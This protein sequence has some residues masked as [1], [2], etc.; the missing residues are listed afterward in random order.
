[1][2]INRTICDPGHTPAAVAAGRLRHAFTLVELMVVIVI[3]GILASLTLAGLAG[4]RQRAK[5]EKTKSTIRK[6][7]AVIQPMYESYLTRRV[8]PA[9]AGNRL[10]EARAMVR[11]KRLLMIGEMPD[12]WADVYLT[13][14][15]ALS[16]GGTRLET[17]YAAYRASAD[18]RYQGAECLAMIVLRGGF[19]PDAAE[20][21][22]ADELGDIDKDGAIEFWD[23]W[24]RPIGFI[25]WAAGFSSL[26]QP[27]NT[28]LVPDPFDPLRQTESIAYPDSAIA[29]TDYA[30]VPLVYSAGPDEATNDPLGTVSGFGVEAGADKSHP[31]FNGWRAIM[32]PQ[33]SVVAAPANLTT[34]VG[35]P[36]LGT[37]TDPDAARDNIYNHDLIKK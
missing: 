24:G 35:S 15:A 13:P 29:Q 22:R 20:M 17:R 1:M 14:T 12:R 28:S 34:R 2:Q 36:V 4:V 32:P 30:L 18:A 19:L 37:I 31:L 33:S 6:I 11:A 27:R 10:A 8:A 9:G 26:V 3:I 16:A 23:G 5:I 7:D 25:R 21:F